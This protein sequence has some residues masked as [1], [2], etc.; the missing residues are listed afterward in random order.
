ME[1]QGQK[2]MGQNKAIEFGQ[3]EVTEHLF[4]DQGRVGGQRKIDFCEVV[5][6]KLN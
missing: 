3:G 4:S 2:E 6:L 5:G 1:F